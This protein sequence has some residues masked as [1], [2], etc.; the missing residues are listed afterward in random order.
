[1]CTDIEMKPATRKVKTTSSRMFDKVLSL[2]F[3]ALSVYTIISLILALQQV[4]RKDLVLSD[5]PPDDR[6]VPFFDRVRKFRDDNKND[7]L[8]LYDY[9][10]GEAIIR[11]CSAKSSSQVLDGIGSEYSYDPWIDDTGCDVINNPTQRAQFIANCETSNFAPGQ[12]TNC[13]DL[14]NY[15]PGVYGIHWNHYV[16]RLTGN[17]TFP[18]GTRLPYPPCSI[19]VTRLSY[20]PNC[21]LSYVG[22]YQYV[23][24][25]VAGVIIAA[26]IVPFLVMIVQGVCVYLYAKNGWLE[27]EGHYLAF[28]MRGV[29]GPIYQF[30]WVWNEDD[31]VRGEF[32]D[33]YLNFWT[34]ALSATT[35]ALEGIAAPLT[36]ILGCS[37]DRF[38]KNLALLIVKALKWLFDF[39][40][41]LSNLRNESEPG[42]LVDQQ[43][44][45][46]EDV[47][48]AKRQA[49]REM[50]DAAATGGGGVTTIHVQG[51]PSPY[52]VTTEGV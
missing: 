25:S 20:V 7:T 33:T 31:G 15:P 8:V 37:L 21:T 13:A 4:S 11:V 18:N 50:E 19:R 2:V 17:K 14:L 23:D 10:A 5:L 1:M 24:K 43:A 44:Q 52:T 46:A 28:A 47:D 51:A 6:C 30:Y 42:S 36:S 26:V 22:A 35:D 41:F 48:A 40:S 32:P 38:P 49:Q 34:W 9:R 27:S 39:Y 3:F 29:P 12:S 45:M 16:E